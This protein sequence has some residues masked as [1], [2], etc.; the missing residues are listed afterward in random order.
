M[1]TVLYIVYIMHTSPLLYEDPVA[2]HILHSLAKPIIY[3]LI[4]HHIYGS[5]LFVDFSHE[6][7]F[8]FYGQ[9][10]PKIETECFF[11]S[12]NICHICCRQFQENST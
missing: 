3:V 2:V 6:F 4:V 9:F 12:F 1:V 5:S 8:K 11:L 7:F 10:F